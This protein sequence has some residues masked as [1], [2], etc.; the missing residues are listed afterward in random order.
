MLRVRSSTRNT[1]AKL[2]PNGTTA[3]LKTLLAH[4]TMSRGMTGFPL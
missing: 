2:L 3:L 4:G 1:P